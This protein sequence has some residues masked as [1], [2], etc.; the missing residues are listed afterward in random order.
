MF[1]TE[2]HSVTGLFCVFRMR[3]SRQNAGQNQAWELEGKAGIIPG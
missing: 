3:L 2:Q 1:I